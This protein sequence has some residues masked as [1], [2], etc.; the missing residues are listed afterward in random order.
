MDC[1][2]A[3]DARCRLYEAL[4]SVLLA[5]ND[6]PTYAERMSAARDGKGGWVQVETAGGKWKADRSTESNVAYDHRRHGVRA[7]MDF[8]V[9][10]GGRAGVSVHGLRGSADMTRS[11]G[12]VE[13]SGGGLGVNATA[14][15]A[16]D[17][18]VD[19]QAAVTWYDVDV[20]SAT[21]RSLKKDAS[22]RGYALG[23]EAGRR[24]SVMDGVSV[25]PRG[26]LVW[27]KVSLDDFTDSLGP[28]VSVKDADSLVGRV[29]LMVD[30]AVGSEEAPGRVFG[31]VDVEHEFKDETSVN[32]PGSP[33]LKTTA[34]STGVRLGFGGEF[35]VDE[36][37]VL[38]VRAD[39]TTSGGDTNE[40][41]AGVQLNLRF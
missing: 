37:V 10:E 25:T 23:V 13:L 33:L 16:G 8:A 40:Y 3:S 9:G 21:G 20:D 14:M 6:L 30:R 22:G 31:S 38:R 27:S 19:A 34:R 36:G 32:V 2:A 15:V 7:G 5:M 24:M 28:R 26:G 4:P 1:D 41:G 39:Y 35:G 11:G 29:G 18:H 12:E 17:V